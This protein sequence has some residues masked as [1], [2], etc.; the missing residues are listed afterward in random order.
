[1]LEYK[2]LVV[3]MRDIEAAL[4]NL[5]QD[6]WEVISTAV[7]SGFSLTVKGTQMVVTL[8]RGAGL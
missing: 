8:K 7:V 1:M 2:T 4:N 6:G 5:A 3:R